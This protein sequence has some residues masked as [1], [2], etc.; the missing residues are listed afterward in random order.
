MGSGDPIPAQLAADGLDLMN[1]MLDQW[2]TQRQ[3]VFCLHE[4]IHELVTNQ[5]IYTIGNGGMVGATFTG[6]IS[7][8][9][10]TVTAI[11]A[12]AVAVGQTISGA[13]VL[14]GTAITSLGTGIGG[15]TIGALGTYS[16][17]N[18]QTV[19]PITFTSYAVRPLRVDSAFARIVNSATGTLDYPVAVIA[20]GRYERLGIKTLP[21]PWPRAVYYQPSEPL[22]TLSY[23]PNPSQA[24][25]M[26]LFCTAVLNQF[27]TLTDDIVLP[28]G[29]ALALRYG[30]AELLMPEYPVAAGASAEVRALIPKYAA[31][32]RAF[33]KRMN[34][35]PQEPAQLDD[36]IAARAGP[37]AGWILHGGFA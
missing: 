32:G 22:G 34:Q 10:L 29:Y 4:V 12:G 8:T 15:N 9:T 30:L 19:G 11:S 16:V 36:L 24:V 7:G 28:Q 13:G 3:M 25:E 5:Y 1:D 35:V 6:S 31:Q 21:G 27:Q 17:N 2:S 20:V 14:A 26:H 37:D 18:S 33:V 23:W